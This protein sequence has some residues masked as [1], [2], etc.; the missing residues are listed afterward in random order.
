MV[1]GP[2]RR[3]ALA[4]SLSQAFIRQGGFSGLLTGRT[5]A[6]GAKQGRQFQGQSRRPPPSLP[7][8]SDSAA[9]AQMPGKRREGP[10]S[11]G[12]STGPWSSHLRQ[13][14]GSWAR[15]GCRVETLACWGEGRQWGRPRKVQ[16]SPEMGASPLPNFTGGPCVLLR[17]W[18]FARAGLGGRLSSWGEAPRFPRL[19]CGSCFCARLPVCGK[20][21]ESWFS[22]VGPGAAGTWGCPSHGQCYTPTPCQAEAMSLSTPFL[23]P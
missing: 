16:E 6:Q 14:G 10:R 13:A 3:L 7:P 22:P 1:P 15:Q 5:L 4:A 11:A 12:V 23:E 2:Y 8:H 17:S 20:E 9:S 19:R 18:D 21:G